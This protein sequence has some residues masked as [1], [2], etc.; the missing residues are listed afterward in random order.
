MITSFLP[1]RRKRH[2]VLHTP[3]S[4]QALTGCRSIHDRAS[5]LYRHNKRHRHA[6]K[7][8]KLIGAPIPALF[9]FGCPSAVLWF[10]ALAII[11]TLDAVAG[12]RPRPHI[13]VKCTET[14]PPI[15][16]G[17]P[18]STIVLEVGGPWVGASLSHRRPHAVLWCITQSVQ[19]ADLGKVL[20]RKAPTRRRRAA[21][22][23]ARKHELFRSAIAYAVPPGLASRAVWSSRNHAPSGK[24]LPTKISRPR[25][26][27]TSFL[28]A[29]GGYSI[30]I[31]K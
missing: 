12:R 21:L 20:L 17:N 11:D 18:P 14:A 24:S 3:P 4:L 6:S 13:F 31:Y 5:D 19:K 23:S 29:C 25:H 28:S 16:Y 27:F 1:P 7:E 2:G 10:V 30:A 8:D 26:A 22:E 9:L 15:A